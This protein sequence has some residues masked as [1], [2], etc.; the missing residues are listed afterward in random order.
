M[1]LFGSV[2][3]DSVWSLLSI[4]ALIGFSLALVAPQTLW[5]PERL[6]MAFGRL[7]GRVVLSAILTVVYLAVVTPAGLLVR[8]SP[9]AAGFA[10]WEGTAPPGEGWVAKEEPAAAIEGRR[11]GWLVMHTLGFFIRKRNWFLI[12]ALVILLLLGMLFFFVQGSV[13]AP[14]IYTL[15]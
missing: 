11:S 10:S 7:L 8:R 9:Q 14:F 2:G 4:V 3:Y 6:W 12:P 13:L 15:F 1:L 5:W